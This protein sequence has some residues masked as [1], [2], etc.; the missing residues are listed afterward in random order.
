MPG[1][2]S[3]GGWGIND[4]GGQLHCVSRNDFAPIRK[5]P[6]RGSSAGYS[7]CATKLTREDLPSVTGA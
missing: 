6:W 7:E 3:K 2:I 4:C 5:Q 1:T